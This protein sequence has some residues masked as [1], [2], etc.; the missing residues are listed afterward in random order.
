MLAL[1]MRFPA[2]RYHATPWERHVNEG[3]VAWPPEPWRVLRALL[4]TW[5]HKVA[6]L[7]RYDEDTLQR[8]IERLSEQLPEY[9]LPTASH[10]HT[11]HYMPQFA[12]GKTSLVLDAFVAVDRDDPLFMS[13]PGLDVPEDE[14]ALLDTLLENLGYL[15]RAESWVDARRETEV[16]EPNCI[17]GDRGLDHETGEVFGETVTVFAPVSPIDYASVRA[18]FTSDKKKAKK[19]RQTLPENLTDALRVE[20]AALR[21]QGWN[22]PPAARRVSYLRAVDALRPHRQ[23]TVAKP[24]TITTACFLVVGKP[25]PRVENSLRIGELLRLAVMSQSKAL[26]GAESVPPVFSGHGMPG[27]NNHQHAFYL[28]VDTTGDGCIDRVVVHVPAGMDAEQ[29]RVLERVRKLW[30]RGGHEWRLILE[31]IGAAAIAGEVGG[32]ARRWQSV[33][34][35][36]HPWHIKPRLGVEDQIR[37]EC[38]DRGLPE[39]ALIERHETIAPNHRR[40]IHFQRFRKKRGQRQ[41]DRHGSFWSLTFAEPVD[42]PLAL[43]FGCHFGLGLYRPVGSG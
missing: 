30:E 28:A 33:T 16:P 4:A 13:W 3:A 14:I 17:P 34:P 27:G 10:S 19:L 29:Q 42:G 24:P 5:H 2:G 41:P 6:P 32:H 12:P 35:Y 7:G 1:S 40:P 22:Q 21:K 39:L 11:R 20:T 26:F 36:L 8:L 38:K 18:R 31:N 25:S 15:G 43:G 37:R 9:H 23:T